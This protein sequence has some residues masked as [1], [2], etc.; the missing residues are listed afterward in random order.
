MKNYFKTAATA[1]AALAAFSGVA[2][3]DFIEVTANVTQDTRWTRDNVYI[4]REI[5]YVLPPAK[6]VIEPGTVIRG[7]PNA[8]LTN[9]G[10]TAATSSAA[11]LVVCRGAKIVANGTADDPIVFTS[12]DDPRVTGGDNTIPDFIPV[13][14]NA[15]TALWLKSDDKL[16]YAA[17]GSNASSTNI[18]LGFD[19]VDN[20]FAAEGLWG[21]LILLGQTPIGYDADGD[22]DFLHYNGGGVYATGPGEETRFEPSGQTSVGG[23]VKGGNGVGFALIEG[24]QLSSLTLGTTFDNGVNGPSTSFRP[25]VYGG[26]NEADNSGVVRF[27]SCRYGG[28]KLADANEI[29]GITLGGCGSS[30]VLEWGE[31]IITQDDGFEFFGGYHNPRYLFSIF[32]GD[33][34]IDGDQGYQGFVQNAFVI[35]N[36][37]GTRSGFG[38]NTITGRAG[39]NQ[40]DNAFE[41]DGA[42][43][44]D[45]GITPNTNPTIY[46][47]TVIGPRFETG[48]DTG[49]DGL[50]MRRSTQGTWSHGIVEDI[51]DDMV[52]NDNPNTSAFN[53]IIH[54]NVNDAIIG[55]G[56]SATS[57]NLTAA[58]SAQL[59]GKGHVVAGGLDPRIVVGGAARALSQAD[60][61]ATY[62]GFAPLKY[63]GAMRDNN[64]LKGWTLAD[65]IGI[66]ASGN[67]TRPAVTVSVD[68]GNPTISFPVDSAGLTGGDKVLYVIEKSVDGKAFAPLVAL[69]D[70][71]AGDTAGA[72][73]ITFK[74][75]TTTVGTTPAHYR[76]IPQ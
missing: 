55:S 29:N 65:A 41:W 32:Q 20:A 52:R 7:V 46:N 6:L 44:N 64:M 73:T 61:S 5:I 21:G 43:Q 17:G 74:D 57:S 71:A 67:V 38:N 59:R 69:Q 3:A 10:G 22:T 53:N 76:V 23:D 4:M 49:R 11:A 31:T 15:G 58:G 39:G 19:V 24:L 56:G 63:Q 35:N 27:V 50:R 68:S 54:F 72:G 37:I 47:F 14:S 26:T 66:V 1:V 60:P 28:F 34:G 42:E 25:A 62:A 51:A 48:V 2:K 8:L 45:S 33:D 16:S 12:I 13:G 30:T 9:P 75:T 36:N 40:S 18:G 70:D